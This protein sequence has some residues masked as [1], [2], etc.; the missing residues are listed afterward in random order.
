MDLEMLREFEKPTFN[1]LKHLGFKL[2]ELSGGSNPIMGSSGI[3]SIGGI[4]GAKKFGGVG[5]HR[6][7]R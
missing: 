2:K 5:I 6:F 3:R 7:K 1:P 4:T